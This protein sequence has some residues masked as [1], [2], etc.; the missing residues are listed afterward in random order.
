MRRKILHILLAIAI[1]AI[2]AW[3]ISR[4]WKGMWM[5]TAQDGAIETTKAVLWAEYAKTPFPS[6]N[7]VSNALA[8]A[9]Q[10]QANPLLL[11]KWGM[12]YDAQIVNWSTAEGLALVRS[13]GPD[14]MYGTSDDISSPV[15]VNGRKE[16]QQSV[17]GYPPQGV[18]SPEP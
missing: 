16:G 3:Y 18:G 14:R 2:L 8:N 9:L 6:L 7:E 4:M 12:P 17:P 1:A 10:A 5:H 11:D 15:E 13:A